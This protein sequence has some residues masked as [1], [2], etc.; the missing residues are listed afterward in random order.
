VLVS[1]GASW[2]PG[3]LLAGASVLVLAVAP[4]LAV[5]VGP[6]QPSATAVADMDARA[7]LEGELSSACWF[8]AGP[9]AACD[10]EWVSFHL[11]RAAVRARRTDWTDIYAP[12]SLRRAWAVA[13]L[14][15]VLAVGLAVLPGARSTARLSPAQLVDV[16]R[17]VL[18]DGSVPAELRIEL[19]DRLETIDLAHATAGQL[20]ELS[21]WLESAAADDPLLRERLEAILASMTP[22]ERAALA[23]AAVEA[24]TGRAEAKPPDALASREETEAAEWALEDLASRLAADD[25]SEPDA[26]GQE[27]AGGEKG[28]EEAGRPSTAPGEQQAGMQAQMSGA[29]QAAALGSQMTIGMQAGQSPATGAFS[30]GQSNG[31]GMPSDPIALADALA[32]EVVEASA[33]SGGENVQSDESRRQAEQAQSRLAYTRATAAAADRAHADPPP[34]VP[35]ARRPLLE[36]YFLRR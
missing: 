9:A 31:P 13:G 27:G 23:K 10:D 5:W 3:A 18:S 2:W 34:R 32:R 22:E 14:S 21:D 28:G 35:D 1:A 36:G 20:E 12:P 15:V 7:K 11:E 8:A 4:R 16:L 26:G 30:A 6:G 29:R 19:A 25:E 33:D 24:A 17:A